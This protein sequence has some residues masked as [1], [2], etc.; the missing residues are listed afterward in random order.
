MV[1]LFHKILIT[2]I[3]GGGFLRKGSGASVTHN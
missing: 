2:S 1:M 3:A